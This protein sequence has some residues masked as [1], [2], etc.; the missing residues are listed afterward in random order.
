MENAKEENNFFFFVEIFIEKF[1][2]FFSFR[3]LFFKIN[4]SHAHRLCENFFCAFNDI[5]KLWKIQHS[6]TCERSLLFFFCFLFSYFYVSVVVFTQSSW[7]I[8][9]TL[10]KFVRWKEKRKKIYKIEEKK[11]EIFQRHENLIIFM[12]LL[13]FPPPY[14][15]RLPLLITRECVYFSP[16]QSQ[17]NK[18]TWEWENEM[19]CVM[20]K[21]IEMQTVWKE[22]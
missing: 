5:T 15:P 6:F 11:S 19:T 9:L 17:R 21:K 14:F 3:S 2:A 12:L 16:K 20:E 13:F 8:V 10:H 7:K 1:V 4:L 22:N 18:S